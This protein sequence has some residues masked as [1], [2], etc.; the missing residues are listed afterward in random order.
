MYLVL[1]DGSNLALGKDAAAVPVLGVLRRLK[2]VLR[3]LA[4]GSNR[5]DER[6]LAP[7][8]ETRSNGLTGEWSPGQKAALAERCIAEPAVSL[9]GPAGD[10]WG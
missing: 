3:Q 4:I 2:S 9:S 5:M 10:T 7:S 8:K 6:S 1:P